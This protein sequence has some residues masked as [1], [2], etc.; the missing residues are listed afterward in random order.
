ME[1]AEQEARRHPVYA[2]FIDGY[3]FG[4]ILNLFQL[5]TGFSNYVFMIVGCA[6][7]VL[8]IVYH[9]FLYRIVRF[10]TFGELITA[11]VVVDNH[12]INVNPFRT[13]RLVLWI[14]T[15]IL[16]NSLQHKTYDVERISAGEFIIMSVLLVFIMFVMSLINTGKLAGMILYLML[17]IACIVFIKVNGGQVDIT[18]LAS[19]A[20]T[21]TVFGVYYYLRISRCFNSDR[22]IAGADISQP[23]AHE[24]KTINK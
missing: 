12:K 13:N 5:F 21:L 4:A 7:M 18:L 2:F 16:V 20:V 6:L 1:I 8:A 15:F 17:C 19:M 22:R 10:R 14:I 9:A 23:S 3:F 11:T 24:D